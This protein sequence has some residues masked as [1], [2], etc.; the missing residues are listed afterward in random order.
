[1]SNRSGQSFKIVN[2]DF[3]HQRFNAARDEFQMLRMHLVIVLRLFAGENGVERD[4][5]ALIHHRPR[6]A[7]HFAD[8]ELHQAGNVFEVLVP[9]GDDGVSGVR[10]GRVGPK[11]DNVTETGDNLWYCFHK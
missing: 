7:H 8:M 9:A 3:F 2:D 10:P 11:D 4:L 1:M 6:A 5:I